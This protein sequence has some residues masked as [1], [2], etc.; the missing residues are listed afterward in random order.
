MIKDFY[1]G[2]KLVKYG[3]NAK[4][5]MAIGLL[6]ILLGVAAL[7]APAG[8]LFLIGLLYIPLGLASFFYTIAASLEYSNLAASSPKRRMIAIH[9]QDVG[10]VI[11]G[12]LPY[13]PL[14]VCA[15]WKTGGGGDAYGTESLRFSFGYMIFLLAGW[16]FL[17]HIYFA[18]AMRI[19]VIGS[20][21]FGLA[22]GIN[23]IFGFP[24][25]AI[26]QMLNISPIALAVVGFFVVVTGALLGAWTRRLTYR[27][28]LSKWG[29][30][31]KF[32]KYL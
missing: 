4:Q 25:D 19:Y 18:C 3:Y 22:F 21:I 2:M 5:L 26:L 23:Y 7:F 32:A 20:I 30:G 17:I 1:K 27:H 12:V 31:I 15:Y 29:L 13:I 11:W 28:S 24:G 14:A 10:S 8:G 9:F 16:L 6:F